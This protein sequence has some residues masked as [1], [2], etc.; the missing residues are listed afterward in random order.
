MIRIENTMVFAELSP[1]QKVQIVQ[2]LQ[3]NGHTVGFLGDGMNDL[4]AIVES[5]VGHICRYC[6]GS[7]Q[8]ER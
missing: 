6:R 5:H 3:A 2:T 1:K 7:C 4:P 8:R